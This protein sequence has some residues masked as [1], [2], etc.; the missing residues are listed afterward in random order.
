MSY[1]SPIDIIQETMRIDFDNE[2][3][4]SVINVGIKV[5]KDELIKALE[6]DRN[7]YLQGY[8]E[9]KEIYEKALDKACEQL[10]YKD[11]CLGMS[12]KEWK[13]WCL[14]DD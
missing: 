2:I 10:E 9:S 13:E 7:Q 5:N 6:Y 14:K 12:A 11:N 1:K 3:L 4:K 8:K